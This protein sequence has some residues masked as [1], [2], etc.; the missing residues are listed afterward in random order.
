MGYGYQNQLYLDFGF[1]GAITGGGSAA[2]FGWGKV[3]PCKCELLGFTTVAASK[4]D[5][6]TGCVVHIKAGANNVSTAG[7][8]IA[9]GAAATTPVTAEIAGAYAVLDEGTLLTAT[10]TTN[11][12]KTIT[13]LAVLVYLRTLEA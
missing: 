4:A 10:Q 11:T 12:G 9:S 7:A 5:T 1:D 13:D 3:L 8:I 6:A 2:V